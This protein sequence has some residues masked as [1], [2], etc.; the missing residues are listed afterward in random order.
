MNKDNQQ[1]ICI[2]WFHPEQWDRL[3]EI[4]ED[5]EALHDSY[6]EWRNDA[7]K[8]IQQ[9]KSAGQTIKKVK[10]NLE[11]LLLC[12]EEKGIPVNGKS[13]AEYVTFVTQQKLS[14]QNHD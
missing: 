3:I 12:R 9:L 4:S 6:E 13:R 8:M 1:I 5:S 7:N 10:F 2:S 14:N 11:D